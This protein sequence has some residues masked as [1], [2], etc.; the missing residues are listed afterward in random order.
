MRI[1]FGEYTF[2]SDS[3]EIRRDDGRPVHLTPKAFELLHSLIADC[4]RAMSKAE[5]RERLW[6][7]VVV[8]EANL[9]N[10]VAEIRAVLGGDVIR[11]VQRHGYAFAAPA[12]APTSA[13]LVGTGNLHHLKNGKNL[14]GRNAGCEVV[15]D[16]TG[17]SRHHAT[18]RVAGAQCTIEDL[19]S[20]NGT[21]KNEERLTAPVELHDGD[22]VRFGALALTF[23]S[24]DVV[25][26]T[27]AM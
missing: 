2:D 21:W 27:T 15:L 13:R 25:G 1:Q 14:I 22:R 8:A 3:R 16:F 23:R 11:T 7:D 6:P 12:S 18:I 20:K 4:P 17:V 24:T 9:K 19:G 26:T 10:L 5:L